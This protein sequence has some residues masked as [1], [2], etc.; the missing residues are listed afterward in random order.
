MTDAVTENVFVSLFHAGGI[1][2]VS[3]AVFE[4]NDAVQVTIN[5]VTGAGSRG[6]IFTKRA[7]LKF[8]RLDTAYRFLKD[9]GLVR[10]T[11][12]L[13]SWEVGQPELLN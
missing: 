13:D 6:S 5:Y 12:E 9:I 8:Y 3:L 10:F 11:S 7:E 1:R 2:S 4:K